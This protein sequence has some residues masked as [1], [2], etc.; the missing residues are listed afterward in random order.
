[1]IHPEKQDIYPIC[2][3]LH[4]KFLDND[5]TWEAFEQEVS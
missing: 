1:M 2:L 5:G 4:R 3:D